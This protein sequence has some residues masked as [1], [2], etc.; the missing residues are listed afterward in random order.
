[1]S[2]FL[3]VVIWL[4][5]FLKIIPVCFYP[6]LADPFV[7]NLVQI[8]RATADRSWHKKKTT[9]KPRKNVIILKFRNIAILAKTSIRIRDRALCFICWH[10][11][12]PASNCFRKVSTFY[13]S[14]WPILRDLNTIFGSTSLIGQ[15]F[16]FLVY[17]ARGGGAIGYT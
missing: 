4:L 16:F 1:M 12:C 8:G 3:A 9:E 13:Y 5:N 10:S 2:R 7:P 14:D 17:L 11:Q 6:T 15:L